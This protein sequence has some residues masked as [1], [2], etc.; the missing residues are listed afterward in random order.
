M[1]G[2]Q[3]NRHL[4]TFPRRK[5]VYASNL[6][7]YPIGF[8]DRWPCECQHDGWTNP[9][10]VGHC[11]LHHRASPDS[12]QAHSLVALHSITILNGMVFYYT[13]TKS[14]LVSPALYTSGAVVFESK[15]EL[16]FN[17]LMDWLIC[18]NRSLIDF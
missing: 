3:I 6:S 16:S 11:C 2:V 4:G 18:L 7:D 13:R 9:H 15:L 14:G 8:V 10:F 17:V 5:D 1:M 12:G